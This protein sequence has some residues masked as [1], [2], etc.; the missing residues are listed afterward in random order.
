M[1]TS[2]QVGDVKVEIKEEFIFMREP[3]EKDLCKAIT[4]LRAHLPHRSLEKLLIQLNDQV[5]Q[6]KAAIKLE[7]ETTVVP[8]E[9]RERTDIVKTERTTNSNAADDKIEERR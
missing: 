6:H 2:S 7:K 4:L 5:R 1:E 8:I 9:N 3:D